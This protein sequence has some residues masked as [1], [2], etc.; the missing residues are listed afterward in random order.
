MGL[1][2]SYAEVV[3][4]LDGAVAALH[5]AE[6]GLAKY[7]ATSSLGTR[8]AGRFYEDARKVRVALRSLRPHLLSLAS[9]TLELR[10]DPAR[11]PGL[12]SAVEGLMRRAVAGESYQEFTRSIKGWAERLLPAGFAMALDARLTDY[13][14]Q[15]KQHVTSAHSISAVVALGVFDLK[16]FAHY[17]N[18]NS[19]ALRVEIKQRGRTLP[20]TD[21][22]IVARV[23]RPTMGSDDGQARL[24]IT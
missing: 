24:R 10:F 22:Q 3:E 19:R 21:W 15:S 16:E 6:S 12:H 11:N 13:D 8:Q 5:V 14:P 7:L 20:P 18:S 17:V 1:K 9:D 4:R 2:L 23:P